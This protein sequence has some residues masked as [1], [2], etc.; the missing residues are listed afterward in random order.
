MFTLPSSCT[1][2]RN[3]RRSTT[4]T[5]SLVNIR[6]PSRSVSRSQHSPSRTLPRPSSIFYQMDDISSPTPFVTLI[7]FQPH[8]PALETHLGSASHTHITFHRCFS[9]LSPVRSHLPPPPFY[10]PVT[11][12]NHFFCVLRLYFFSCFFCLSLLAA[13]SRL[14]RFSSC[15]PRHHV[16]LTGVFVLTRESAR[17]I[18][19]SV[20]PFMSPILTPVPAPIYRS[21]P[22][23]I[24]IFPD[25]QSPFQ[26]RHA[27]RPAWATLDPDTRVNDGSLQPTFPFHLAGGTLGIES[28]PARAP[29]F[30]WRPFHPL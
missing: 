1:L 26:K 13:P 17:Y 18:I 27:I 22:R 21:C 7:L 6:L 16:L 24:T 10:D 9:T 28:L 14:F 5:I 30:P 3:G 8:F 15:G 25:R 29:C 4:C 11:R 19:S 20:S 23:L 12:F 2:L